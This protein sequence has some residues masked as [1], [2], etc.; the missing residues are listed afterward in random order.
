MPASGSEREHA[1]RRVASAPSV[2]NRV[3]SPPG[4]VKPHAKSPR[5]SHPARTIS[6]TGQFEC[7]G[8]PSAAQQRAAGWAL[9]SAAC[10]TVHRHYKK[11]DN[12]EMAPPFK[13]CVRVVRVQLLHKVRHRAAVVARFFPVAARAPCAVAVAASG[14]ARSEALL[15]HPRSA[16]SLGLCALPPPPRPRSAVRGDNQ[17]TAGGGRTGRA[18]RAQPGEEGGGGRRVRVPPRGH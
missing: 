2:V 15:I 10:I 1:S 11:C 7:S 13:V 14:G 12:G 16:D 8:L 18:R 9:C 5:F 17:I 6:V 3:S 4:W